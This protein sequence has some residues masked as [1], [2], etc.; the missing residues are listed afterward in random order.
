MRPTRLTLLPLLVLPLG[1]AS[2]PVHAYELM[3]TGDG[4]PVVWMVDDVGFALDDAATDQLDRADVERAAAKAVDAWSALEDSSLE[5]HFDGYTGGLAVGYDPAGNTN[6][7]AFEDGLW[8]YGDNAL[9]VTLSTWRVPSGE[10]LDADIA[11]NCA[12]FAWAVDGRSR[13]YDLTSALT[14][15]L[16]HAL[17]LGHS[18]E[19]AAT[20]VASMAPSEILK[21]DLHADDIA[22][23]RFLYGVDALVGP[24]GPVAEP[25]PD[26]S[27]RADTFGFPPVEDP[28]R[29]SPTDVPGAEDVLLGC[30]QP[31][32]NGSRPGAALLTALIALVSL[33]SRRRAQND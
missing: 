29:R 11:V 6:L 23:F 12:D 1:A 26:E 30:S 7:I 15:E 21:R 2:R 20:M 16:G 13:A 10:L 17:G 5:V 24:D 22:G 32:R 18:G 33:A 28:D 27:D 3:A 8:R 19:P 31:P 25:D 14:H 9:A 4:V